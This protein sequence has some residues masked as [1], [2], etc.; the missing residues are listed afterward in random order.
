MSSVKVPF[1]NLGRLH[2]TIRDELLDALSQVIDSG[3]FILGSKVEQFEVN[4]AKYCGVSYA[5][6]VNTGTSALHL[7]LLACDI[8]AGD[9]VITVS[10]TFVATASAIA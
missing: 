3:E 4:F 7:A 2:S 1:L 10:S 8:G 5:V 6:G 9:E